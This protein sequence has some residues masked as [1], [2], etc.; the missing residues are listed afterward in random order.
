MCGKSLCSVQGFGNHVLNCH[1]ADGLYS[2]V[3]T[4]VILGLITMMVMKIEQG[5]KDMDT[6]KAGESTSSVSNK[7]LVDF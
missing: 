5:V 1:S 2:V 4:E 7:L 3:P 6:H